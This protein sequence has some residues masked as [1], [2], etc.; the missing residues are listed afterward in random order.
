MFS[1]V[2][3][4]S[5]WPKSCSFSKLPRYSLFFGKL[6]AG[7]NL[8]IMRIKHSSC[9][10]ALCRFSHSLKKKFGFNTSVL[11]LESMSI[12]KYCLE[13]GSCYEE[14]CR[15]FLTLGAEARDWEG[16]SIWG[17]GLAGAGKGCG[18]PRIRDGG[19]VSPCLFWHWL[20]CPAEIQLEKSY[21]CQVG[22]LRWAS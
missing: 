7:H 10:R 17:K 21:A 12:H 2:Q 5:D 18:V 6:E 19:E 22:G 14:S 15:I 4:M 16:S 9:S 11:P 3:Q 13:E 8:F 20:A 1:C